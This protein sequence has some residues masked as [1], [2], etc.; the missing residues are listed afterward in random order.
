MTP[1]II[2]ASLAMTWYLADEQGREY[3][4][5]VLQSL[6][7]REIRVPALFV[8][9]LSNALVMAH[10]RNR[11]GFEALQ[12]VFEK[13]SA[14]DF[15]IDPATRAASARLATLAMGYGLT[16]YDAAYL[17][18]GLRTG[19]PIATLDMALIN[20]MRATSVDLVNP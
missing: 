5:W 20:A 9:E 6:T 14:M 11:I 17:D 15:A 4:Q 7:G 1:W 18:L 10:R 13:L 12:E 8:Y 16:C 2:D 3:G 19:F